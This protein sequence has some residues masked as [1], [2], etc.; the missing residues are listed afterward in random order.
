MNCGRTKKTFCC[1]RSAFVRLA[2][3]GIHLPPPI[4]FA[5]PH[6]KFSCQL[7]SMDLRGF[8]FYVNERSCL[9]YVLLLPPSLSFVSSPPISPPP[10]RHF[11]FSYYL[12][13]D[14]SHIFS[15][16]KLLIPYEHEPNIRIYSSPFSFGSGC[17]LT[18]LASNLLSY[19]HERWPILRQARGRLPMITKLLSSPKL[20]TPLANYLEATE[21]F[22]ISSR[23]T[24]SE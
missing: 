23:E 17:Y 2:R 15:H 10:I 24:P 9:L 16:Q 18:S 19:D 5:S 7:Y 14:T 3:V 8:T 12:F 11:H 1:C 13:F 21:R 20:L 6:S 22:D 4:S